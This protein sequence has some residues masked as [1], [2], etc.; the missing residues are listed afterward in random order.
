MGINCPYE[1]SLCSDYGLAGADWAIRRNRVVIQNLS[2]TGLYEIMTTDQAAN[3]ADLQRFHLHL[4]SDA[5]G[6]TI[7]SVARACLSQFEGVEPQEHH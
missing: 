7:H 2:A 5:T 6:E 1:D 4:V 3:T